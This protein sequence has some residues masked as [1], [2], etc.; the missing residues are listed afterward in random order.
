[1]VDL[2]ED[3]AAQQRDLIVPVRVHLQEHRILPQQNPVSHLRVRVQLRQRGQVSVDRVFD[4]CRFT[5]TLLGVQ[6]RL[7]E[8][9]CC[10]LVL[11]EINASDPVLATPS[12]CNFCLRVGGLD[13]QIDFVLEFVITGLVGVSSSIG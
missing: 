13:V 7:R 4:G 1:V 3:D 12:G 9:Q 5:G 6:G 8:I 10:S 11:H 2:S